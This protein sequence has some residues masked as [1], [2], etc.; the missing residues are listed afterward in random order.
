M[1]TIRA[2]ALLRGI[3][4]G[5]KN[6]LPMERLRAL[7][8]AAGCERVQTYIQSGNVVFST[9]TAILSK[10]GSEI[11]ASIEASEGLQVPVVIRTLDQMKRLVRHNPYLLARVDESTLHVMFLRDLPSFEQV[12]GIDLQRSPGDFY[13]VVDADVF[14]HMPNGVAKSKLT[15]AYFDSKLKTVSTVRNWRTV[16]QLLAMLEAEAEPPAASSTKRSIKK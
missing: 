6:V 3:N 11:S 12:A 14:M 4:V 13:Q 7:F 16:T 9:T 10:L 5:G 15:N 8:V 1:S 2:I